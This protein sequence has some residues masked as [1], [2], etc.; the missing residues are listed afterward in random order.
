MGALAIVYLAVRTARR[1]AITPNAFAIAQVTS[2]QFLCQPMS[3]SPCNMPRLD[4]GADL[5]DFGPVSLGHDVPYYSS[6]MLVI[7]VE[8]L[9][10]LFEQWHTAKHPS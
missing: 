2:L 10:W 5:S 8:V 1:L 3:L 9:S 6:Q 4:F 7:C